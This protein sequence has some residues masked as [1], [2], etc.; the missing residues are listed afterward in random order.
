MDK[1][2][3]LEQISKQQAD[4]V[5]MIEAFKVQKNYEKLLYI[6]SCTIRLGWGEVYAGI[7]LDKE[8]KPTYHLVVC[9]GITPQKISWGSTRKEYLPTVQ[10]CKLISAN[11]S[12]LL[13]GWHWTIDETSSADTIWMYNFSEFSGASVGNKCDRVFGIYVRRIQ[14]KEQV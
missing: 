13:Q 8:E 7:V 2:I 11:T 6:P 5:A 14:I 4:L 10:E 12:I 1:L 9:T 3:T